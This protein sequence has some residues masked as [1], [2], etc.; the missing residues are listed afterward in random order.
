MSL[1]FCLVVA[2]LI[3]PF[4]TL[5]NSTPSSHPHTARRKTTFLR[6]GVVQRCI[7]LRKGR[8]SRTYAEFAA[9][10]AMEEVQREANEDTHTLFSIVSHFIILPSYTW[11]T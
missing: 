6:K 3:S 2:P 9:I 11:K 8:F 1:L 7:R 4:V 5:F 10:Q